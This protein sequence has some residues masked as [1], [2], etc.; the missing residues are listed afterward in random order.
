[1]KS[2]IALLMLTLLVQAA[3]LPGF[4]ETMVAKN[5]LWDIGEKGLF[6]RNDQ[7]RVL[8]NGRAVVDLDN[9]IPSCPTALG[10]PKEIVLRYRVPKS[11]LYFFQVAWHP[12]DSGQEQFEIRFDGKTVATSLRVDAATCAAS[13]LMERVSL[14]HRTAGQHEIVL[15]QLSGD[16]IALKQLILTESPTPSRPIKP[17]LQF[18]NLAAYEKE[19][20]EPGIVLDSDNVRLF[21]P[22]SK[23]KAAQTV[24]PYLV[25]A[26]DE[27]YRM[28]G[29]HTAYKIMV[30]HFPENNPNW[31]GGTSEC[32]IWYGYKNL[33]LEDQPEWRLHQVPHVMG[34]IEEMGHNFVA[35]SQAMFGWEMVGAMIS[36]QVTATVAGNPTFSEMM[37]H[38]RPELESTYRNYRAAGNVFP[39]ELPANLCD[40]IHAWILWDCE[41]AYGPRFWPNF[42]REIGKQRLAF[43][44]AGQI[45]NDDNRRNAAYRITVDCFDRLM[46]GKFKTRLTEA[47]IS[48]TTDVKSLQPMGKDWNRR[49]E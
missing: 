17:G 44:Q 9:P 14:I 20:K 28:V 27:Y 38:A 2:R 25:K 16:G 47:G 36:R 4:A 7:G 39:K 49:L 41:Q 8:E 31:R 45:A 5:A 26:Y 33:D 6:E 48:L 13:E 40:R 35:A 22:K 43:R 23:E 10:T 12:G 46:E 42:F 30:Y 15:R 32:S 11:E 3:W 21:A 19:I 37:K 29:V 24:F 34:Y 1:M 18:P